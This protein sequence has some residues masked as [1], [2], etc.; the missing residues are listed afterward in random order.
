MRTKRL[1]GFVVA[2]LCVVGVGRW[3]LSATPGVAAGTEYNPAVPQTAP[4]PQQALRLRIVA[5]SDSP[6]DQALKLAIRNQVVLAAAHLLRHAQTATEAKTIV[7]Q[8]V[9]DFQRIA[10][11]VAHLHGAQYAVQTEVGKV[12]FP[13]KMYGNVVYP[14]GNYEALRIVLGAGLGH[15]WWCVL[16]PPLC[17]IDLTTGDAVPNTGGF[18]DMPPLET[19]AVKTATGSTAHVAVRLAIVDYGEEWWTAIHRW[20]NPPQQT[21]QTASGGSHTPAP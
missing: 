20:L 3:M 1:W 11:A 13:T 10:L 15:N 18:P 16:F 12:P 7:A 2:V 6:A 14:A 17:F 9:A 8:H 21:A 4:I 5:N 19:I